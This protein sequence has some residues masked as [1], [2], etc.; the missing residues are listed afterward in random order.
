MLTE[1]RILTV[2]Y[3]HKPGGFCKRLQMKIEAYLEHGWKVHYIAVEPF[4]YKHPNLTPHILPTPMSHHDSLLFWIYFFALAP[5]FTAW[6]A[7]KE[8]I[9]L[10]SIFS[11][12]YASVCIP[13]KW[14]TRAPLLTFIRSMKEKKEFSYMQ[15]GIVH[16]VEGI[17]AKAGLNQSDSIVVNSKSI[18]DELMCFTESPEKIEVIHN[19]IPPVSI[20]QEEIRKKLVRDFGINNNVFIISTSGILKPSKNISCILRAVAK[21]KNPDI[22]VLI[23]GEGPEREALEKLAEDLG[24]KPN[25]LFSGWCENPQALIAGTDLFVFPSL[26]E[27]LSNSVLEALACEIPCLLS[28]IEGN[29]EILST[30]DSFFPPTEPEI[31]AGI[32]QDL[33]ESPDKYQMLLKTNQMDKERFIFDWK[34]K[35]IEKAEEVIEAY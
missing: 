28:G 27:G 14:V 6:V 2:Y 34:A 33:I 4:P 29:R 7:Y 24:L 12:S 30:P 13:A 20:N 3:K 1:K 9:Q 10:L 11:L 35:I 22:Y 16:R 19:H 26:H 5:W 17:I 21:L 25:I 15:S 32:I 18:Q 8:K 23:I 31:L